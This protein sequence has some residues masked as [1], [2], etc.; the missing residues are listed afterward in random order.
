MIKS[1][2]RFMYRTLAELFTLRHN[3]CCTIRLPDYFKELGKNQD[4]LKSGKNKQATRRQYLV[5][6]KKKNLFQNRD[7]IKT[8]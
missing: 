4:N 6:Q 7:G 5:G 3:A 1:K 8:S 2:L